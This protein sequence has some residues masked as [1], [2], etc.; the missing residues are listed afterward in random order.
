M[1]GA[2]KPTRIFLPETV[3]GREKSI[4]SWIFGFLEVSLHIRSVYKYLIFNTIKCTTFCRNGKNKRFF[5][6]PHHELYR[7]RWCDIKMIDGVPTISII[8]RKTKRPAIVPLNEMAQSL[9]PPRTD[10]NPESLVFHL[11]KKSDNVS[12]YVRRLKEKA[13]IEKDLTYHCSRH[14]TASLAISAGADISAV[15]DILG[16]GSITS[17]EVYAKVALEKKIETVNLFNG[18]FD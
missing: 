1:S 9:L 16:H 7:L 14:T 15:K 3:S 8:Q 17:T 12:K 13:G 10:D 5:F 2:S 11:V 4:F 6:L 18:V